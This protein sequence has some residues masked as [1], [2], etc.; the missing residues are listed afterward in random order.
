MK[1]GATARRYPRIQKLWHYRFIHLVVPMYTVITESG[2]PKEYSVFSMDYGK[3]LALKTNKGGEKVISTMRMLWSCSGQSSIVTIALNVSLAKA[4]LKEKL[5]SVAGRSIVG[6][7]ETA[8]LDAGPCKGLR[9][10]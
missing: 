1:V 8:D 4:G 10:R 6:K 7:V 9:L 3:L 5:I 2:T